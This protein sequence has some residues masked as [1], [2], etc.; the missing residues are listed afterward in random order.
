LC[1]SGGFWWADEQARSPDIQFHFMLGSGIE[2]G[3]AAVRAAGVTL[4]SAFLRPRSRGTVKLRS[5]DPTAAPLIDPNYWDE[6]FDRQ[7]SIAGLEMAREILAKPALSPFIKNEALPGRSVR[8]DKD[9]LAYARKHAKTDYH[10]VGTCRMGV[11]S[12]SVVDP[13]NL[14]VRG[15][16]NVRVCDSSIMPQLV[17][18]NTNAPTIMIAEKG[19]DLVLGYEPPSPLASSA[20]TSERRFI[21]A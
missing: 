7:M 14:V 5:A 10:P 3:A 16:E 15:L 1:E 17:S 11:G 21:K 4:N 13:A 18:A 2:K 20:R 12:A 6:P 8:A 19:A 9:L